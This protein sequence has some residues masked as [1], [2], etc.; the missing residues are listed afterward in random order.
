MPLFTPQQ[1]VDFRNAEPFPHIV[2]DGFWSDDEL[3]LC[4]S[5]FPDAQGWKGYNDPRERG[6]LCIDEPSRWGPHVS[7]FMAH[8]QSPVMIQALEDLTGMS[9]LTC[10]TVGGGM[11]MTGRD[12]R[13][14]MHVDFNVHPDGKRLRKLNVLTFINEDWGPWGGTLWLGANREVSVPPS[15]NR[16][17]I[18]ECSDQSWHGHPEPVVGDHWRKS[19]AAYYYLPLET[20]VEAHTTTWQS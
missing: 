3:R 9:G 11:H 4:A 19:L 2:V 8:M 7:Q 6:K 18:F 15:W 10:D 14:G 20:S 12:G 17:V 13:L 5:E 16:L 1:A